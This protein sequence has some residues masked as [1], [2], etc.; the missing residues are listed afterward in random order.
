MPLAS[1]MTTLSL[2]ADF[3]LPLASFGSFAGGGGR[4]GGG[5]RR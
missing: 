3:T 5:A 1:V 4:G 2:A